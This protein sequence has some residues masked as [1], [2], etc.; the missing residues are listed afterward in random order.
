MPLGPMKTKAQKREGMHQVLGEF[1]R[2][3]LHSGSKTGPVVKN[4]AQ[5]I[6]IAMHQTGQSKYQEGGNIPLPRPDPRYQ[7]SD[8]YAPASQGFDQDVVRAW[9]RQLQEIRNRQKGGGYARGG[10]LPPEGRSPL[11][12][13]KIPRYGAGFSMHPFKQMHS[14]RGFLKMDRGGYIDSDIPG[15]TDKHHVVVSSGS[16]VLP[17]DHVSALGQN[18]SNAGAKVVQDMFA[19]GTKFGPRLRIPAFAG[20]GSVEPV[21]IIVAGGEVILPP[22]IVRR[23]GNGDLDKGHDVLDKWVLETRKKHIDKLKSLKPPKG[24]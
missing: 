15:R 24:S 6:A 21:P 16:Y 13:L 4:R 17:A 8:D 9:R 2:G 23:I 7:I 19:A 10:G 11:G 3:Q 1:K 5:A 22:N 20:G 18:N 14:G 12:S